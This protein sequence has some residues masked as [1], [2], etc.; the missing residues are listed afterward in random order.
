MSL[1]L[2]VAKTIDHY[3]M[4]RPGQRVGVAVSGGADSV[5][6]LHLLRELAPEWELRLTV[7]HLDHGLRGA[8]SRRDAEFVRALANTLDLPLELR[9]AELAGAPGNLEQTARNARL[10]FFRERIA[11]G[12]V[13]RVAVG[14]NRSDQAETVLFRFLRGAATGGLA[15]IRPVTEEGIVRPLIEIERPR[16]ETYLRERGIPW[17]E[18]STNAGPQFAR[19]R[20]RHSLLP[21][22]EREWNPALRQTL[23]H[24]AAW[25]VD[26]E[27]FWKAEIDRIAARVL[28]E[29]DGAILVAVP[30][31]ATRPV[32]VARRLVRRAIER[33]KGDLRAVD[34]EHVSAILGLVA[35]AK[36]HGCVQLPGL[37][38]ARSFDWLRFA[39]RAASPPHQYRMAVS[40]PGAVRVAVADL[41]LSLELVERTGT[42]SLSDS[43]YNIGM[44]C[45]DR[46]R[47]SGSLFVR[48]WQPGDRYQPVGHTGEEK[49]KTLFHKARIPLWERSGWPVLT[50]G[51]AIVWARCFGPAAGLAAG[52]ESGMLVR[53]CD[54]SVKS[55]SGCRSAASNYLK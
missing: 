28:A 11:A 4:F 54:R 6:L 25:A 41:E 37:A 42:S 43:V 36:G 19:N 45:I 29:R 5:C 14:H 48:N 3:G 16:I 35:A 27:T 31:L 22:L 24:T 44:G 50:D 30:E 33:V 18:D 51:T 52:E 1:A 7:L 17:C 20:I 8:E 2:A 32:A 23:A 46:Q 53:V 40:V 39:P 38:V 9:S 47:L 13:D 49:I 34:F 10:S 26:E 55:E 15:G 12:A 21:Q